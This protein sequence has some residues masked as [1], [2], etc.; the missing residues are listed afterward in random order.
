M[1]V[2][3]TFRIRQMCVSHSSAYNHET[4][5]FQKDFHIQE[6]LSSFTS[7]LSL[8][9]MLI[10]SLSPTCLVL[11]ILMRRRTFGIMKLL[12]QTAMYGVPK[13]ELKPDRAQ[14]KTELTRSPSAP[15]YPSDNQTSSSATRPNTVHIR[16]HVHFQARNRYLLLQIE[17]SQGVWGSSPSRGHVR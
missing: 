1:V 12:D 11:Q 3:T 7:S 15:I 13:P 6:C 9:M 8:V 10:P 17:F 14:H 4:N 16:P 2:G 5:Y